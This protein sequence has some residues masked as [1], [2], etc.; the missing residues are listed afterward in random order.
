MGERSAND[1]RPSRVRSAVTNNRRL[2]VEADARSPWARRFRDLVESHSS[3]LAGA[4][5]LS[6][7]QRSL[8]RRVAAMEVELEGAEG[9]MSRGEDVDLAKYAT[10]ANS[11]RRI[12]ETL[13][14]NRVAKDATPTLADIAAEINAREAREAAARQAAEPQSDD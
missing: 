2:F 12:L 5:L 3:D 7:A 1:A 6:E 14:V 13:G 4:E 9:K 10:V 11:L 8:I